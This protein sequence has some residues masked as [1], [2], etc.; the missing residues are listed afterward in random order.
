VTKLKL[1]ILVL[2]LSFPRATIVEELNHIFVPCGASYSL[3]L[4]LETGQVI[5]IPDT[6]LVD[7]QDDSRCLLRASLHESRNVVIGRQ[8][9]E[10]VDAVI[11]DNVDD[12]IA[13]EVP[14]EEVFRSYIE[15]VPFIPILDPDMIISNE[16]NG[17]SLQVDFSSSRSTH[18][19]VFLWR[20]DPFSSP[21]EPYTQYLT[22]ANVEGDRSEG[23]DFTHF[24]EVPGHWQLQGVPTV[25]NDKLRVQF[26][27]THAQAITLEVR[28]NK[29]GVAL[30][31]QEHVPPLSLDELDVP[32]PFFVEPEDDDAESITE[33][34]VICLSQLVPGDLVQPMPYC[35]HVF[36]L[37]CIQPWLES[38][39]LTCP[40]C[41]NTALATDPQ[42]RIE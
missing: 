32:D 39:H 22:F 14:D 36:H 10:S 8:L 3:A 28:V 38:G 2:A 40:T 13:F 5:S 27:L 15:P 31:M 18:E 29:L 42:L 12:Q 6:L 30:V 41:R 21:E 23:P 17:D 11:L 9:I 25:E 1:P 34:C 20:I 37:D 33:E 26:D 4:H 7:R 16:L 24:F 35:I 19:G